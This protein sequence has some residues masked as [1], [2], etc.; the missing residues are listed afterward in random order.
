M[1]CVASMSAKCHHMALSCSLGTNTLALECF[2]KRKFY[3][4]VYLIT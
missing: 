4:N 2:A 3:F 1:V